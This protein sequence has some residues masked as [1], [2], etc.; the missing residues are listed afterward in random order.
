MLERVLEPEVMDSP[1]DALD[2]D[3]MDHSQVNRAFA[4]AFLAALAPELLKQSASGAEREAM[5]DGS[6]ADIDEEEVEWIEVLDVGTG[7]ALVP[8]EL[9]RRE[10]RLRIVAVDL[11][12]SML[13]LAGGNVEIA[14]L[15]E[16]IMLDR[17]DAKELP[18]D[19][20]RFAAVISNSIMHHIPRP[21][22]ALAEV[23]RV[24]APGGLIFIRDLLRP[25][26]DETVHRL[27]ELYA[28]G[29]NEHQRQLFDDSLRAALSL[30][31]IRALVAEL[32]YDGS[33]V[34]AS[35]DRHWTWVTRKH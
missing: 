32:G 4:D 27:V 6:A 34:Q 10:P 11:A 18:Y 12:A 26:D 29:A 16:R 9:C 15:S 7:T 17:I 8:I 33:T 35:S 1:A 20:G 21:H 28:A 30:D 24:T 13:Y 19:K 31:E 2:Y 25:T 5:T 22:A 3:A 14:E 23:C